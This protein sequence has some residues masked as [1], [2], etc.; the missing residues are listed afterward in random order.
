MTLHKQAVTV[1]LGMTLLFLAVCFAAYKFQ[2]PE[3]F[4][5]MAGGAFSSFS[6]ALLVALKTDSGSQTDVAPSSSAI[7]SG[8]RWDS[9]K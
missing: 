1:L 2:M 9:Q 3:A 8:E 5:A 7:K 6:G 4:T